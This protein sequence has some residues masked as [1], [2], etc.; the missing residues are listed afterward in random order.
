MKLCGEKPEE[1]DESWSENFAISKPTGAKQQNNKTIIML[2][3]I[4][5]ATIAV[6]TT[7]FVVVKKK[8]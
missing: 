3:A 7:T 8:Q 1:A 4:A 6:G 2:V 5:I